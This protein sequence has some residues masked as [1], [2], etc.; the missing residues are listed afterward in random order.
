MYL[1]YSCTIYIVLFSKTERRN[2]SNITFHFCIYSYIVYVALV[3]NRHFI[4]SKDQQHSCQ[5]QVPACIT[6]LGKGAEGAG[7]GSVL[8]K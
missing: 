1:C 6:D 3:H 7:Q 2:I 4:H 5:N 8:Q